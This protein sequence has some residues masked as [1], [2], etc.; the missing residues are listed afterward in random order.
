MPSPVQRCGHCPSGPPFP[1]TPRRSTRA[2]ADIRVIPCIGGLQETRDG[3]LVAEPAKDGALSRR[4]DGTELPPDSPRFRAEPERGE[5]IS[6][7][8]F[9]IEHPEQVAQTTGGGVLSGE[10]E[11][12][13]RRQPRLGVDTE[14][15][16]A[17]LP[18]R[19]AAEAIR[20]GATGDVLGGT[21]P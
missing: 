2:G 7:R 16:E 1:S 15:L 19:R 20:G 17:A 10:E 13:P 14:A 4:L 3:P 21:L 11:I 12:P 6:G 8:I 9:V 18:T 5:G